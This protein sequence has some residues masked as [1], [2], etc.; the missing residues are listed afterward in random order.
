MGVKAVVITDVVNSSALSDKARQALDTCLRNMFDKF[1]DQYDTQ[2]TGRFGYSLGDEFQAVFIS[3]ELTIRP[4][5]LMHSWLAS[6]WESNW[7][8]VR[9]AIGIGRISVESSWISRE[10]DGPAF[11]KARE[12]IRLIHQEKRTIGISCDGVSPIIKVC[13]KS[14]DIG[15]RFVTSTLDH[16]TRAQ[17]EVAYWKW[18]GKSSREIAEILQVK[19]QNIYKRLKSAKFELVDSTLHFFEEILS[20]PSLIDAI[21]SARSAD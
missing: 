8:R 1:N 9:S 7:I 19:P 13:N 15:C 5:F 10:Q 21:Q 18:E 17:W 14:F 11:Y 12:L 4:V 3:A 6:Q 20:E 2:L 16:W